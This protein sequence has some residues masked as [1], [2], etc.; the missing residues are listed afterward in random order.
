MGL[1]FNLF[2]TD[3]SS[4]KESVEALKSAFFPNGSEEFN[5]GREEL[6]TITHH[7]IDKDLAYGILVQ[8]MCI[9]K[10]TSNKS[11]DRIKRSVESKFPYVLTDYDFEKL[12]AYLVA[13]KSIGGHSF[14]KVSYET[15]D[16]IKH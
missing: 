11:I 9:F 6:L 10:S 1:F 12:Y 16:S 8:A 5:K 3:E 4:L 13:N 7:R 14:A 2:K 15:H